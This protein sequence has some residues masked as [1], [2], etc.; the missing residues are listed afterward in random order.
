MASEPEKLIAQPKVKIDKIENLGNVNHRIIVPHLRELKEE[1]R[2]NKGSVAVLRKLNM[3]LMADMNVI[4]I[5][6]FMDNLNR[7]WMA[8]QFR[9][10]SMNV[11][12]SV[13][14][15]DIKI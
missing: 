1:V 9:T 8:M 11:G 2:G 5:F 13:D 14:E 15:S 6:T 10:K 4:D 7:N 12:D 3:R